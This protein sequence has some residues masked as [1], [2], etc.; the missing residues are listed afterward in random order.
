MQWLGG[1][2]SGRNSAYDIE[3]DTSLGGLTAAPTNS[4]KAAAS[5]FMIDWGDGS[6]IEWV[7]TENT[8]SHTYSSHGVY[9]IRT[10]GQ[11]QTIQE[12]TF[13]WE[14]YRW[15]GKAGVTQLINFGRTRHRGGAY[16]SYGSHCFNSS[17]LKTT[18][19]QEGPPPTELG[20]NTFTNFFRATSI[21]IDGQ[22][23]PNVWKSWNTSECT[24]LNNFFYQNSARGNFSPDG[25][26]DWDV[27][28]VTSFA[29]MF[30]RLS[31]FDSDLSRWNTASLT[32][33]GLIFTF[34]FV[35]SFNNG[36]ATGIADWDVSRCTDMRFLFYATYQFNQDIGAW[37]VSSA[38]NFAQ[39][40]LQADS[41]NNAGSTSIDSWNTSN[42]TNM[43]GMFYGN[44]AF[45][46]PI[47]S[48]NVSNVNNFNQVFLSADVF[49]QDIGSWDVS[50]S[51]T[52]GSMFNGASSFDQDISSWNPGTVSADFT[53]MLNN[54][55]M[56]RANYSKWLIALANWA[57]YNAYTT[58][59]LLGASSLQYNAGVTYPGIGLGGTFEDAAIAKGYLLSLGWTINDGGTA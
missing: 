12:P 36:G 48:W 26:S 31:D 37:D 17:N 47:G 46:Q 25:V 18:Y 1:E 28:K 50:S 5:S 53:N 34:G 40:F 32:T 43:N 57:S 27:S 42:V 29:Y 2:M 7:T 11:S 22:Y 44:N 38:T 35:T 10:W 13:Q 9:R 52:M 6:P 41:F 54:C 15:N 3:W 21:G 23:N 55:G 16:N 33:A 45:N 51:T 49:N 59:E 58:P 39:M 19:L 4:T 20:N 14:I 56:G 30:Y 8:A 24:A